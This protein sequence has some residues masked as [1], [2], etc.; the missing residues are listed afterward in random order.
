VSN[1]LQIIVKLPEKKP[2][3]ND[4]ATSGFTNKVAVLESC[5]SVTYSFRGGSMTRTFQILAIQTFIIAMIMAGVSYAEAHLTIDG[6]GVAVEIESQV[7]VQ[8]SDDYS[9][10]KS[11]KSF[12]IK[13]NN[14]KRKQIDFAGQAQPNL[15]SGQKIR[16][17]GHVHSNKP[18]SVML[19]EPI[20]ATGGTVDSSGGTA[21]TA[22]TV[23]SRTVISI[24][25]D[26]TDATVSC[27]D[28]DVTNVL[29][30][31]PP[32]N[33]VKNYYD[34]T[35]KGML[36]MDGKV[37]RVKLNQAIGTTCDYN[38][39]ASAAT[40]EA[41][42]II[43]LSGYSNTNIVLPDAAPCA[44]SGLGTVGW[45]S[46]WVKTCNYPS[47]F[48][49]ELGHNLG[50]W[51]AGTPGADY[52]DGSDVMGSGYAPVNSMHSIAQGWTPSK[53]IIEVKSS[54]IYHITALESDPLTATSPQVLKVFR[55]ATN[56]FYYLS[57]RQ[58]TGLFGSKYLSST[59]VNRLSVHTPDNTGTAT[60]D[61]RL[62]GTRGINEPF[63]D[64]T[65]G[66]TITP[67]AL[68]GNQLDVQVTVNGVCTRAA[69]TV[70]VSGG[71]IS[72]AGQSTT[73]YISVQNNDSYYCPDSTF[74][75]S[76]SSASLGTM[77]SVPTIT[78]PA[79]GG[80]SATINI[81]STATT[82]NGTYTI[83]AK[84]VDTMDGS[85]SA[86]G[87]ATVTVGPISTKRGKGGTGGGGGGKNH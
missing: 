68:N 58:A 31:A 2:P 32:S 22:Q 53:N 48:A 27:T 69:P 6:N 3:Q 24:I 23:S 67:V 72:A 66:I 55:Q 35:S 8:V 51:H 85:R 1:Q 70:Y 75:L 28:A 37:V 34:E 77:V 39:W 87:S 50:F 20:Q 41:A 14:G 65:E 80:S 71:A 64:A 9:T 36:S 33:S 45:G 12:F 83:S 63:T 13:D 4:L 40:T 62:Q 56:D 81:T 73:G 43:S 49:H 82:L 46:T 61:T 59:F 60:S 25:T 78:I 11:Q 47:V 42:K 38:G 5:T 26:F 30:G 7:E 29:F 52:G 74:N 54:G 44:W 19:N 84:A 18:G 86:S 15:V 79:R 10:G 57:L 21:V 76:A 16:I 17:K